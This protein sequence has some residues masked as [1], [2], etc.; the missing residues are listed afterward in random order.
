MLLHF[1]TYIETFVIFITPGI[2]L[3][4][5]LN[6]DALKQPL[7]GCYYELKIK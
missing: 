3:L 4:N 7:A 1:V 5:H 6:G 2:Y